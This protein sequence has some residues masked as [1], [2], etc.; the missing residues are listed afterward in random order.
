MNKFWTILLAVGVFMARPVLAHEGH[1]HGKEGASATNGPIVGDR[2]QR[3]SDGT[4]F[5]PKL[6]QRRLM[7]RT[8][9]A[10]VRAV[11]VSVEMNGHVIMDP[12]TGGR[13]QSSLAGRIEA[14]PKGLPMLGQT[15]RKGELLAY[16][17]PTIGSVERAGQQAQLAELHA[18]LGLA[19]KRLERQQLLVGTVPRKELDATQAEVI[20]LRQRIRVIQS[21]VSGGEALLAPV[22]GTIAKA[23]VLAGQV[24]DAKDILFEIIDPKHLMIEALAYDAAIVTEIRTATLAGMPTPLRYLGGARSLRDGALP[25]LFAV[26][27][28][29]TPLAIGQPVKVITQTS[30][31]LN[32]TSVPMA[33]VVRNPNNEPTVWLHET[34]ERFKPVVVT[35]RP[36]DGATVVATGIPDKARVVVNGAPLLNQIR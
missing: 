28:P 31:Q 4:V 14:G 16:V 25:L 8:T 2:P 32:G 35:V 30:R 6:A 19:E 20:S 7:I 29:E 34:A 3:L 15:V 13:V 22:G 11:P 10:I 21:G 27:K 24:I 5:L 9:V 12:N 1:S 36:L 18:A 33:A 17:K 26:D 23:E